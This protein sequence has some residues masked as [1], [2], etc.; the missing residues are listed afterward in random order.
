MITPPPSKCS[1]GDEALKVGAWTAALDA[2][3]SALLE[4]E[5]PEC[6]EG[7][8]QAAWWLD[9]ADLVF[10]V[11]ARAY[12]SYL[13]H[14]NSK[15]A[16]RVAVWMAWDHWA[17][18][19]ESAVAQGWLRRAR[20]LL[21]HEPACYERAW[22]ELREASFRLLAEAAA[23]HAL[24]LAEEGT[25]LARESGA[26]DLEMLGLAIQGL[27]KVV[28]GDVASGIPC[29]DE[30]NAAVLAGEVRDLVVIGL[31]SCYLIA[32]C[33]R[34]RD[35]DRALQWCERLKV[36]SAE[37]GLRPLFA[38]CRTQYASLC[39][40]RGSWQEAEQE[41]CAAN[42]ELLASR[43]AMVGEAS[44]RL[45]ELR[46]KQG[47]LA[48]ASVLFEACQ[49][50]SQ[51]GQAEIAMDEGNPRLAK[52]I[53]ERYL[54]RTPST[55]RLD[56]VAALELL[57]R[58]Q[59]DLGEM[60]HAVEATAEL[61]EI[62]SHTRMVPLQAVAEM[63]SGYITLATQD[64]EQARQHF[65]D[66]LDAYLK[67]DSPFEQGR[68]RMLLAQA[69]HEAG[70][71]EAAIGHAKAAVGLFTNL[72]AERE[73]SRALRFQ[74]ELIS[75]QKPPLALRSEPGSGGLTKRQIEVLRLVAEGLSN[76]L[77]GQRLFLSE[78]TVHRHL[79]NI[80]TKLNASSRAAAIAQAGRL[81][82]LT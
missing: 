68:A 62:A 50:A 30:A 66:A 56:R 12:R 75:A 36:F 5:S 77:I 78:H 34:V 15:G 60:G 2:Y 80:L 29:L 61:H 8:G 45:G 81:G 40:W 3:Q 22:L 70:R 64:Y 28:G 39:I 25:R 38:V 52:D 26:L 4:G 71:T 16:A 57:V 49:P 10:D 7:L 46:R 21:K 51:L 58:S 47:R 33:E 20:R 43:P 1:A 37:W 11:R 13:E 14:Q 72:G 59:T 9:Q 63:A 65:E 74:S 18:R 6:L 17:F 73:A 53:L 55:S 32:A 27:A 79:S 24:A 67:V 41:L 23:D 42:R 44:L 48:E 19:G 31:T 54:R 35:F 69:L 82:L 76:R